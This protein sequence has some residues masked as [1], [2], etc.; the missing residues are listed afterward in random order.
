MAAIYEKIVAEDLD[1]GT[2]TV[3]RHLPGGGTA[4]A[5][6]LNIGSLADPGVTLA[7]IGAASEHPGQQRVVTDL[8][9]TT[10][11]IVAVGGGANRGLVFSN[12]AAWKVVAA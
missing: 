2:G 6:Q 10:V 12:G 8:T 11:N 3:T 9:T 5:S 4:T 7:S 1:V